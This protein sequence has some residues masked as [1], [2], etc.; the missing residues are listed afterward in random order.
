MPTPTRI[1]LSFEHL[2]ASYRRGIERA[3]ADAG[4]ASG[5][6]T[7]VTLIPLDRSPERCTRVRQLVEVGVVVALLEPFDAGGIAHAVDHG[8][9]FADLG[10]EPEQVVATAIAAVE[11]D[12]RI[13]LAVLDTVIGHLDSHAVAELT[14][15]ESAWLVALAGGATVVRLADE[16]G[17][18]ERALFRH[19]HD[20]YSRLGAS[21]RAEALV[22]AERRGLLSP[23]A[24]G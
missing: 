15:E 14:D 7:G 10:A 12:A 23:K 24:R 9:W 1:S 11:G 22:V 21:N 5:D 18:S 20:L 19:L 16:F 3:A 8:A 6:G 13:P 17:Y 4:V 2:P